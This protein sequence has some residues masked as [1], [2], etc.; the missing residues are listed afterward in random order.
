MVFHHSCN[1]LESFIS[2]SFRSTRRFCNS[3]AWPSN[4]SHALISVA[5]SS[6]DW[7]SGSAVGR[8]RAIVSATDGIGSLGSECCFEYSFPPMCSSRE[9]SAR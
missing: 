6:S 2:P 9:A 1:Q 7:A 8:N 3:P 4:S 5:L